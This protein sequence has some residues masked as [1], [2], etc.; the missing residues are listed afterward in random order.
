MSQGK[1]SRLLKIIIIIMGM[2]GLVFYCYVEPAWCRDMASGEFD[3][4]GVPWL[5]FISFTA[6]PIYAGLVLF[7][8][9]CSDIQRDRSFTKAN[10][11]RLNVI[12]VLAVSDVVYHLTGSVILTILDMNHPGSL[13][14]TLFI[15]VVG[16]SVAIAA[17]VLAHL[18]TKA[19]ELK[20]DSDLTI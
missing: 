20:E 13:L 1:L 14:M 18:V 5:V 11:A 19:A 12:S 16:I 6:G 7:W 8:R 9:I 4:W 15:D 10:A 17:A 2:I 3:R